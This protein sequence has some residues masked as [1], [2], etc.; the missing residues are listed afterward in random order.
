[1]TQPHLLL[2]YKFPEDNDEITMQYSWDEMEI[3]ARDASSFTLMYPGALYV[4]I[5]H[6]QEDES[7]KEIWRWTNPLS[8]KLQDVANNAGGALDLFIMSLGSADPAGSFFRALNKRF[9]D[10]A[11]S[12]RPPLAEQYASPSPSASK[13]YGGRNRRSRSRPSSRR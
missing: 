3:A 6:V 8:A 2:I 1:M 12:Y 13:T 10:T 7:E 5:V 9:S 11:L 4:Y